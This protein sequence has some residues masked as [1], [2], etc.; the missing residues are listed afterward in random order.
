MKT[1]LLAFALASFLTFAA[2]RSG[3]QPPTTNPV[4]LAAL[5][6][7]RVIGGSDAGKGFAPYQVSI[8]NIF[9]EHVCGGSIIDNYWILTAGHCMEW[10]IEYLIVATGAVNWE[11]PD[12]IYDIEA[13]KIHCLYNKPMYHNDIALLRLSKPIVYNSVTQPIKLASSDTHKKGDKL[14]LTGWGSVKL[15]GRTPDTLQKVEL[16]YLPNSE[17]SKNVKNSAWLGDCHVCS[18]TKSGE[19]SCHGDSGGPLVD[20]NAEQVGVVNWGEPC[21]VGYPDVY[22]GVAYYHDWIRS[23]IAGKNTC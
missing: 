19:G 10:P 8:Q 12:A 16:A 18:Y 14:V 17:C 21:A 6:D 2:G 5:K 11:K 13:E 20:E 7:A 3:I 15:W 9:G 4:V 23:T 22:A 1:I